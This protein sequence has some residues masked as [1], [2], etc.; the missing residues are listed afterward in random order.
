MT[1]RVPHVCLVSFL[2][3]WVTLAISPSDRATW[4]LENVP[5][6]IAVLAAVVT[7]RRF[8][9]SDRAYVAATIFV[10]LHTLG[11]HYTYSAT[12]IG[13]EVSE[14]FGATR[15]HYDR[16]VHFMAGVLLAGPVRELAFAP[17]SVVPPRRRAVLVVALIGALSALYEIVEWL[18]AI[19]V[20]PAA[21]TAFLGTQGDPWDAQKDMAL[22]LCGAGVGVAMDAALAR[23]LQWK[24]DMRASGAAAAALVLLSAGCVSQGRYDQAVS[25]THLT[26]AELAQKTEAL[27][28]TRAELEKRREQVAELRVKLAYERDARQAERF[29]HRQY[30]RELE[31]YADELEMEHEIAEA[32]AE[33][34]RD[35]LLR[36]AEQ[37]DHGDLDVLVRDGRMV[38]RLRDDVLFGPGET[39]FGATGAAALEAV[40]EALEAVPDRD[41]QIA[42]HT[43]SVPIK[44]ARYAS[45][46]ELSM[47]RA[48]RV[49]RFLE[50]K[51]VPRS[52]L[53]AAAYADVD[54]VASNDHAEGRQRNRRIEI[55]LVPRLLP[56]EE[57]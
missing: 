25:R 50:E 54:P 53:S 16:F 55:T 19:V 57:P 1:S 28:S 14:L 48:L 7:F 21:G 20:D 33:R 38:V 9:F 11:S 12:P 15:N 45:N 34:Y 4:A 30:A 5:T 36:L 43:D 32:R 29:E 17:P 3:G 40:A 31:R 52:S 49:L 44:N 23:R 24:T 26:R 39:E 56:M 27:A 41:F 10:L 35:L 37:I 6:V 42:G 46:W 51:G 8:R 18:A 47:A 13:R 22:A 2:V